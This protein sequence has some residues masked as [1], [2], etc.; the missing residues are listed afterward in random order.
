MKRRCYLMR[1]ILAI[2]LIYY[3]PES[4]GQSSELLRLEQIDKKISSRLYAL[5]KISKEWNA[6]SP[7]ALSEEMLRVVSDAA[8]LIN[9][10]ANPVTLPDEILRNQEYKIIDY[11]NRYYQIETSSG[12]RGWLSELYVEKFG[13]VKDEG[14]LDL[15]IPPGST[16]ALLLSLANETYST[17]LNEYELAGKIKKVASTSNTKVQSLYKSI[18]RKKALADAVFLRNFQGYETSSDITKG[19]IE[20]LSVNG[21]L[22]LG[23]SSFSRSYSEFDNNKSK[24]GNTNVDLKLSYMLTAESKI[25]LEGGRRKEAL[26]SIYSNGFAGLGFH[27][28]STRR[29]FRTGLKYNNYN[30]EFRALNDYKRISLFADLKEK[31]SENIDLGFRYQYLNNAFANRIT[32]NYSRHAVEFNSKFNAGLNSNIRFVANAD[33]SHSETSFFKYSRIKPQLNFETKGMDKKSNKIIAYAELFTFDLVPLRSNNKYYIGLRKTK[34]GEK[35]NSTRST[36]SAFLFRQFPNN[37]ITNFYQV[38]FGKGYN[39]YSQGNKNLNTQLVARYFPDNQNFSHADL[40][41]DYQSNS[42]TYYSITS[43]FRY[44]YPGETNYLTTD[45]YAKVGIKVKTFSISPLIGL[46]NNI[47]LRAEKITLKSDKNNLRAG[48][49][50]RGEVLIAKVLRWSFR[51]AYEYGFVNNAS[52]ESIGSLGEIVFGEIIQRNPNSLQL[53]TD[54]SAKVHKSTELFSSFRYFTFNT[55]LSSEF[56]RTPVIGNDRVTAQLGLRFRYN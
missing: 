35:E 2:C 3:S 56:T 28:N 31:V 11:E 14:K 1:T 30:D 10:P 13:V 36:T 51:G 49:E 32:S 22:A 26:Q 8:V 37:P 52:V 7:I 20:R 24:A 45:L 25:T 5:I 16:K 33:F 38:N 53:Q 43:N 39:S 48:L 55:D 42:K 54:L 23:T 40:H 27:H 6:P 41:L 47:D 18:D 21:Q 4:F 29:S 12:Q 15:S 44:W 46:H 9:D 34:A 50:A 19:A 17:L